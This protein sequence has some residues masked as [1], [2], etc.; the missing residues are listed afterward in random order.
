MFSEF[1]D[2]FWFLAF[3]V[4][5]I[6]AGIG[7]T[8]LIGRAALDLFRRYMLAQEGYQRDSCVNTR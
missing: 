8:V 3:V 6:L 1:A 7:L 5:P 4:A 2:M